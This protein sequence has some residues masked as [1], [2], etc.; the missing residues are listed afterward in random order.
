LKIWNCYA[1]AKDKRI[2]FVEST[3]PMIFKMA[4]HGR[5]DAREWLQKFG[6]ENVPYGVPQLRALHDLTRQGRYVL[7]E[8]YNCDPPQLVADTIAYGGDCDQWASVTMAGM[9]IMGF[10]PVLVT[11]GDESDKFQHV[12]TAT[13]FNFHWF[14]IDPKGSSEGRDFDT[15]E[16]QY[17]VTQIWHP[18]DFGF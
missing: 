12:A 13:F 16:N 18:M 5:N 15:W 17:S 6:I 4:W 7:P 9:W 3:I 8:Q 14:L 10:S 2:K 1:T 11:F